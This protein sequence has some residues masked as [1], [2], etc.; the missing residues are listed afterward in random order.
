MAT[1]ENIW[2]HCFVASLGGGIILLIIFASGWAFLG[3]RGIDDIW[4]ISRADVLTALWTSRIVDLGTP[5]R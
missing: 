2:W 3:H 4:L 5:R 1:W